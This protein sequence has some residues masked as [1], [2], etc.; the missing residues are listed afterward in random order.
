MHHILVSVA[1]IVGTGSM[2]GKVTEPLYS[3]PSALPTTPAAISRE[4]Y[5]LPNDFTLLNLNII[6][7][8]P[9]LSWR[10]CNNHRERKDRCP[11]S[12]VQDLA[13][14]LSV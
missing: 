12:A 2:R 14:H 8:R 4:N 3:T 7:L 9:S 13:I 1:V 10:W 6:L 11:L 5:A